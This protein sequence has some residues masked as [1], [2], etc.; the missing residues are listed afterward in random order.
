MKMSSTNTF[1]DRLIIAN[2]TGCSSIYG[3]NLPTTPYTKNGDGRGPAWSNS[4]FEDAAEFGNPEPEEFPA[5]P[6]DAPIAGVDETLE[7]G[8]VELVRVEDDPDDGVPILHVTPEEA[9]KIEGVEISPLGLFH[10]LPG[11]LAWRPAER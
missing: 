2:A 8:P 1:G 3:G 6:G 5:G 11:P 9:K 7:S 10:F 4:L